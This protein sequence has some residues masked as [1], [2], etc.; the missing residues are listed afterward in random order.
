MLILIQYPNAGELNGTHA[1]SNTTTTTTTIV[2]TI[3]TDS[4]ID[5]LESIS[6][7]QYT[8]N[9]SSSKTNLH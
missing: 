5:A 7:N 8:C 9:Q 3:K 1:K 6:L 2:A 4:T